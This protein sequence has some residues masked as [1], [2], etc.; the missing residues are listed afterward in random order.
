MKRTILIDQKRRQELIYQFYYKMYGQL[1]RKK[2][3][4][5]N[6]TQE[7]LA[8]GI[9]SNTYIS[10]AE[11]NQVAIGEE[12]L[13]MIMEKL[14]I[15]T[16]EFLAPED[17]I[18]CLDNAIKY[19]YLRDYESYEKIFYRIEKFE[20]QILT[21][22][23]KLGYLVLIED[24]K[25]AKLIY[26]ELFHYLSS[27]DD[28]GFTAFMV[29]SAFYNIGIRKFSEAKY[30]VD[31]IKIKALNSEYLEDLQSYLK[32]I[33][34]GNIH[35]FVKGNDY[36]DIALK[37]FIKSYNTKRINDLLLWHNLFLM[38][39]GENRDMPTLEETLKSVSVKEK[40]HYLLMKAYNSDNPEICIKLMVEE[41]TEDYLF[42]QY[43][44]AKYYLNIDKDKYNE[45]KNNI[46]KI[47]YQVKP[48]IDYINLLSLREKNNLM[49]LKDYLINYCLK[50]AKRNE[51]IFMMKKI[52]DEIVEI[53]Q[54]KNRYKDAL[55]YELK[56]K[57]HIKE[58][59]SA[60]T[61][62]KQ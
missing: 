39:N 57:E 54:E 43:L 8:V 11:N 38:Y 17:L 33:V 60:N 55:T 32:Y 31:S 23:I 14:K 40:N 50:D 16:D 15:T 27:L 2:R 44:L 9:C 18:K 51:N 48:K 61:Y 37:S 20:F 26:E 34:Y 47:H 21:Q 42:G 1:I 22:V 6:F 28:Y 62:K 5:L 10:K 7:F 53:L 36:F 35:S 46:N 19:F 29:F 56:L 13:Y 49:F 52:T 25:K 41:Q 24:F 45:V 4:E 59:Q 3:K 58:L 12:Q 30:M